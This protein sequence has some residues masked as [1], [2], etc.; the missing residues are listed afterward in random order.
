MPSDPDVFVVFSAGCAGLPVEASK[1]AVTLSVTTMT[2]VSDASRHVGALCPVIVHAL[3]A[4]GASRMIWDGPSVDDVVG[5]GPD[6][7]VGAGDPPGLPRGEGD[8][9]LEERT[10][11]AAAPPIRSAPP[12]SPKTRLRRLIPLPTALDAVALD[13]IAAA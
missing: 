10:A 5:E 1:K 3:V 11:A 9:P 8:E 2:T 6:R 7:E 4:S 13:G 12:A